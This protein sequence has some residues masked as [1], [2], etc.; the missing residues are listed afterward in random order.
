[1]HG[2]ERGD[3]DE[4]ARHGIAGSQHNQ[5]NVGDR[6]EAEAGGEAARPAERYGV[7]PNPIEE[8]GFMVPSF[9]SEVARRECQREET[10]DFQTASV[11]RAEKRVA[12]QK[13]K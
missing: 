12:E 2:I 8:V 4:C 11:N 5:Q 6:E 13:V 9:V 7:G 1:M 3:E 10:S